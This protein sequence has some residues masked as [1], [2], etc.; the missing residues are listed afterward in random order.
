MKLQL[1]SHL[2][3][4][5]RFGICTGAFLLMVLCVFL[6]SVES[7]AWAQAFQGPA[8][9]NYLAAQASFGVTGTNQVIGII[10]HPASGVGIKSSHH[11][12]DRFNPTN[13][14]W[15]FDGRVPPAY[16]P[17]PPELP[18]A[19]GNPCLPQ[20]QTPLSITDSAGSS[21]HATL[22]ADIA[23]GGAWG[24]FIGVAPGATVLAAYID[25]TTNFTAG[26]HSSR[27]AM[28]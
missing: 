20:N 19:P 25:S 22:V 14:Q 21:D 11:L 16:G 15:N 24:P 27:V 7:K 10:E 28:E 5:T 13:G 12:G 3:G 26:Y 2:P 23:A 8:G 1:S 18:P 17:V 4:Q 9:A 6:G